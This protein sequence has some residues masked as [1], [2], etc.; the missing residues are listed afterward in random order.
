MK[1]R[2]FEDLVVSKPAG[3]PRNRSVA[4]PLS[5]G[6]HVAVA[7]VLIA[8]PV[9]T[10]EALPTAI[11][12]PL[13]PPICNVSPPPRGGSRLQRRGPTPTPPRP[14]SS[15][16]TVQLNADPSPVQTQEDLLDNS[17]ATGSADS[18]TVPCTGVCEGPGEPNGDPV[19]IGDGPPVG[20]A[21]PLV[22][23]GGEI[24]PPTKLRHV[25]PVYPDLA[26]RATVSG[27]VIL[28]C[29]IDTLG[30]VADVRVLKGHPL[31]D[32]AALSAVQQW[33]YTPTRL[34]GSPVAVIMTV[35]V[36]FELKR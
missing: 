16:P 8:I 5:M 21:G 29:V 3:G 15:Q 9:L 36:R 28:E 12:S 1:R 7:A 25:N 10:S 23:A 11:S 24:Q 22:R 18:N 32:A 19:G 33:L 17:A 14:R 35:T 13:G 2:L 30:R 26:K 34:N 27:V 31:L 6:L 4:V 20:N